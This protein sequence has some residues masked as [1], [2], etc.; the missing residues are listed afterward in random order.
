MKARKKFSKDPKITLVS[1]QEFL[2]DNDYLIYAKGHLWKGKKRPSTDSLYY[3]FTSDKLISISY[4][5]ML[6]NY[7]W[8][9]SEKL[10]QIQ[11]AL[12]DGVTEYDLFNKRLNELQDY[13]KEHKRSKKADEAIKNLMEAIK[14]L[15]KYKLPKTP[16]PI[17]FEECLVETGYK[18]V[19]DNSENK[20]VVFDVETNGVRK[21]N[22]DLLSLSIFDPCTGIC[23]NRLFP[24][25][26]QPLVLTG[27][28]HGITDKQL[29]SVSHMTQ[30]E[31]DNIIDFFHL[32]DRILLSF[33]GGKGTFDFTFLTNYCKR[34][35]LNGFEDLQ[36][37]NIKSFLPRAGYGY[38]GQ[39]TKDNL[40]MLFGIDGV[41]ETHSS[42]NDCI[43]EWKLFEK[44][45]DGRLFFRNNHL[46][47]WNE[48]YIIPVSYLNSNPE[49]ETIAK[50][51]APPT[52]LCSEIYKYS[53][54]KSILG[55]IKKFPTN[56]TGIALENG[57]NAELNVNKQDNSLFLSQN[58]Q[59]LEYV[60]SLKS[61]F[62]EMPVVAQADGTIKSLDRENDEYIAEVN[63]VTKLVMEN[64]K[65]VFEYIK[66]E[67]FKDEAI[68]SQELCISD[69]R[70]V[71]AL[72]DLS[73]PTKVLEI[74]TK[75]IWLNDN[76]N[77]RT[78][79]ARQLFYE[80]KGRDVYLLSVDI[81]EH[82]NKKGDYVTDSVGVV[83]Y[84]VSFSITTE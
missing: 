36:Y 1:I 4:G 16:E 34:H 77:V 51:N 6:T 3:K 57:I 42:Q 48:K 14:L 46:Y 31:V 13:K 80:S 37:E 75:P 65:G 26:L 49:L 20:Y 21:A 10:E 15:P 24:L 38:E 63:R 33:S 66:N 44:V 41:Q 67:I 29:S 54:P 53:F 60:W 30:S 69:D 50:I 62:R 35:N 78:P 64:L 81:K 76:N 18:A 71:L 61:P 28:I 5:F 59:Q 79:L 55:L 82:I 56:I 43:L 84:G 7:G 83:I 45:K 8:D 72:C 58:N 68:M 47:R 23:Y 32:K 27:W 25:E 40:C 2:D 74:K 70:K 11:V 17:R 52:A 39:M 19:V 73:S 9:Y 12:R 22:D